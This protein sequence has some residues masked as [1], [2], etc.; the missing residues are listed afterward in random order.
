MYR[1]R[2]LTTRSKLFHYALGKRNNRYGIS[3]L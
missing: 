3:Y 2:L 1:E